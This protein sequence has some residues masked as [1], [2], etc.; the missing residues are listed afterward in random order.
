MIAQ[1]ADGG[2]LQSVPFSFSGPFFS[3]ALYS[4]TVKGSSKV[5]DKLNKALRGELTALSGR[6]L[7]PK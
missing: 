1:Q 7:A 4:P 6:S 5:V 3:P 2:G